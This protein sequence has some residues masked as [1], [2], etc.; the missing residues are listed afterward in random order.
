MDWYQTINGIITIGCYTYIQS[1]YLAFFIGVIRINDAFFMHSASM[2]LP[3]LLKKVQ[4][5]NIPDLERVL[6]EF[7]FNYVWAKELVSSVISSLF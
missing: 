2:S 3:D 7:R 1:C 4:Q 6:R 5:R